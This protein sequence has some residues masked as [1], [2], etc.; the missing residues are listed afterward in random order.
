MALLSQKPHNGNFA[1]FFARVW[2]W[3]KYHLVFKTMFHNY[4]PRAK[5]YSCKACF[6]FCYFMTNSHLWLTVIFCHY[7]P[8]SRPPHPPHHPPTTPHSHWKNNRHII[9]NVSI[10][11]A[12]SPRYNVLF[13]SLS[14][15][16]LPSVSV[17]PSPS[18]S[19]TAANISAW[20][21]RCARCLMAS[22]T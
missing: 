4:A 21:S 18:R 20:P 1:A 17:S 6:A 16:A 13:Y 14:S 10:I 19:L 22:S 2:W 3:I 5:L 15:S 12:Y 8:S 9:H 11:S 7:C